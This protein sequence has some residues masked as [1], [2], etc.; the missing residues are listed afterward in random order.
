MINRIE[1][2]LNAR[3]AA[4]APD[5]TDYWWIE[6][7]E[8][9]YY[10]SSRTARVIERQLQ[11]EPMPRWIVFRDVTGAKHRILA[12]CVWSVSEFTKELRTARRAFLRR[13]QR[14]QEDDGDPWAE[15]RV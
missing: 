4:R 9:G 10:V 3:Q 15:G 8:C 1:Q 7:R 6:T 5:D 13:L 12:A 11:R 2:Y 14:E